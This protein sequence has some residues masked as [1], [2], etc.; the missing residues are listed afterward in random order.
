MLQPMWMVTYEKSKQQ[1]L[2]HVIHKCASVED[3]RGYSASTA[4]VETY[5][6]GSSDLV[7]KRAFHVRHTHVPSRVIAAAMSPGQ[8]M[9][10]LVTVV[11]ST[12]ET[13]IPWGSYFRYHSVSCSSWSIMLPQIDVPDWSGGMVAPVF[14]IGCAKSFAK[15]PLQ[16]HGE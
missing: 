16:T 2:R 1:L 7:S 12:E 13:K 5:M 3:Q 15:I 10:L 4:V 11:P 14:S 6:C 9:L 8:E